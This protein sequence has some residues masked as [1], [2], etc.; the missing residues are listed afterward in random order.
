MSGITLE[1]DMERCLGSSHFH[2]CRYAELDKN[3]EVDRLAGLHD[4][5]EVQAVTEDE[6]RAAVEELERSTD[7]IT[8]QTETLQQQQDA[9]ARLVKKT[10]ESEDRRHDFELERCRKSE[11][12]RKHIAAEVRNTEPEAFQCTR[13]LTNTPGGRVVPEPGLSYRQP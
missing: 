10:R 6:I 11:S 2:P 7:A 5:A 9:L 4:L 12:E 3:G 1:R 8:K 13:K